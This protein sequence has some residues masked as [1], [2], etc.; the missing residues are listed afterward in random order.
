ML[1]LH[2][3]KML[4]LQKKKC[5]VVFFLKISQLD[6]Q[7]HLEKAFSTNSWSQYYIK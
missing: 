3:K 1:F 7:S 2:K 4:F 6:K 5:F